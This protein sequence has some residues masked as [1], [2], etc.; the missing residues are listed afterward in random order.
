MLAWSDGSNAAS[1]GLDIKVSCLNLFS[2]NVD[3]R[4]S[5]S[6]MYDNSNHP[7]LTVE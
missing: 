2:E 5:L 3:L 6:T 4:S 7:S 1:F